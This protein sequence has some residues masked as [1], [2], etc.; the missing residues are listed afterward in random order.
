MSGSVV[1][2]TPPVVPPVAETPSINSST[3]FSDALNAQGNA[4][5]SGAAQSMIDNY[6]AS[7]SASGLA[8]SAASARIERAS[9]FIRVADMTEGVDLSDGLTGDE[10]LLVAQAISGDPALSSKF[11][12]L[13]SKIGPDGAGYFGQYGV[14]G[15]NLMDAAG[16]AVMSVDDAAA[17]FNEATG[18]AAAADEA[19]AEEAATEE[20]G[21]EEAAGGAGGEE[22][23]EEAGG[24]E[25]AGG[26]E[27]GAAGGDAGGGLS[28]LWA[29]LLDLFDKD[30]DGKISPDEFKE[31]MAKLDTNGDGK[32]SRD[33]LVAGGMSEEQ[34]GEM[35][36]AM[37]GDGDGAIS[38]EG[39]DSELDTFTA[40]HNA[41][42]DTEITQAELGELVTPATATTD[43][44][45]ELEMA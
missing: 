32:L 1:A 37:D 28:S 20:A 39:A 44:N 38:I 26:E 35:M 5:L 14:E 45:A 40:E 7:V 6:A 30:G 21:G 41:D 23:A 24:G 17:S 2:I 22:A 4:G 19:A 33:E 27:A 18:F 29:M 16:N 43:T 13:D 3:S 36:T 25:E 15:R 12:S 34:A 11:Q 42:G 9:E 8:G 31:G 10:Y